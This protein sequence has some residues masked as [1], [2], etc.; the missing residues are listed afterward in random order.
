MMSCASGL[1]IRGSG[2]GEEEDVDHH[3]LRGFL[4]RLCSNVLY[5]KPYT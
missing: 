1:G 3:V 5:R 2:L 4:W